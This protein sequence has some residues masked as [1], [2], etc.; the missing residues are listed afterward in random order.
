VKLFS[1]A[2]VG[3]IAVTRS[4]SAGDAT[5]TAG[6][7]NQWLFNGVWRVQVT[8]VDPLM[9]G[10]QQVGWQV[11]E[12]WRNGSSQEIAP[13]DSVL[14]DQKIELKDG[15][16][17]LASATTTGSL[18]LSG[19]AAHTFQTAA[20]FSYVQIFRSPT[21][22]VDPAN[23]AQALDILFDGAKLSQFHTKPQFTTQ[24]YNFRFKLDCVATNAA[25]QAQGGAT[26][27]AAVP[28]CMNQWL[29]NGVWRVRA[30]AIA[31]DMGNDGTQQIGWMI[32]EDWVNL[33]SR[34]IAPGGVNVT[35]QQLTLAGGNTVASSNTAGTTMNFGELANRT[36]PPG[37]SFTYTQ[38]FR[39]APFD[40]S[41]KPIR[42][43]FTFNAK[44][45]SLY[46]HGPY[47]KNPADIR[48]DLTC[49]K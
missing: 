2:L 9:D 18:S 30:T 36:F 28:G 5:S 1:I 29:S 17:I 45:Q 8:K 31:P 26:Q 33:F 32:T 38:R 3:A 13:S 22:N 25:A 40:A 27:V 41:D 21:G 46:P 19:I 39:Q 14:Q 20:Q 34:P 24:Q 7:M 15:S 44:A 6:C 23:K 48:V 16:S 43:L 35:D 12:I 4:V 37:G 47:Y 10:A 11:T 42:L 49:T